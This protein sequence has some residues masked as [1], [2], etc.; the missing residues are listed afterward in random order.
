MKKGFYELWKKNWLII[1]SGPI[2]G[3]FIGKLTKKFLTNY[4][5]PT[6]N[7][8]DTVRGRAQ[9]K[10]IREILSRQKKNLPAYF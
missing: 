10:W 3:L 1:L 8:N 5:E 4:L 7:T 6:S 9:N 2:V